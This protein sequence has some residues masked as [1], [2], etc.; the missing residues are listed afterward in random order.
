VNRHFETLQCLHLEDQ[1]V[2]MNLQNIG[3]YLPVGTTLTSHKNGIFN[4]AAVR[5]SNFVSL[6][7]SVLLMCVAF[8]WKRTY[9]VK[10]NYTQTALCGI[11]HSQLLKHEALNSVIICSLYKS[12]ARLGLGH[13]SRWATCDVTHI[14]C[15]CNNVIYVG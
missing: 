13:I 15:L 11:N 4:Y 9:K 5:T 8:G 3:N 2:T 14:L 6:D 10:T 1:E 7:V 12:L